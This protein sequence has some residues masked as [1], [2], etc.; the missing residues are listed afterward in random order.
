MSNFK[1][2]LLVISD[3]L[4][5]SV[6]DIARKCKISPV[7]AQGIINSLCKE[8]PHRLRQLGNVKQEGEE[9][10]TTGDAH[11][12]DALGGG[13]RTGMV[14]EVVG[15]R[16]ENIVL[17]GISSLTYRLAQLARHN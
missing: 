2:N 5:T 6:A 8:N 3:I 16:C 17:Q 1:G 12:D 14:W 4:S 13:I 11:L 10:F 9:K 7:E 15:E